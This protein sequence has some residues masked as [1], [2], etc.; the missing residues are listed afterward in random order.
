[1][2]TGPG[3]RVVIVGGGYIGLETAASLRALGVQV[4]VLEATGRVLERVTA[5]EVSTF[6][7]RIHREQGVDIRTNAMVQGLSGDREVREI[8]LASGESIPAD[9]V[10]VG[11][12]VETNPDFAAAAGLAIDNGIVIDNQTPH[13]HPK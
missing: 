5:P 3:Q 11:V 10:I 12:G 2:A 9:L 6:F 4:T 13:N 7:E 8:T 1:M